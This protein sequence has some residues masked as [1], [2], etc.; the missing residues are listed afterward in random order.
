MLVQPFY[1]AGEHSIHDAFQ[2]HSRLT[3][4]TC[5]RS[6]SSS[7]CFLLFLWL[8]SAKQHV[9]FQGKVPF[10]PRLPQIRHITWTMLLSSMGRLFWFSQR[11]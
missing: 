1:G 5:L 3:V 9:V 10:V 11:L 2:L 8:F 4:E 6:S 7:V